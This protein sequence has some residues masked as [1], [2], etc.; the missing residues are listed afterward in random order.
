ML[1]ELLLEDA[2]VEPTPPAESDAQTK[3]EPAA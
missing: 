2:P 3:V 1:N